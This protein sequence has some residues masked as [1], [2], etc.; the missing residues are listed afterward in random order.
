MIDAWWYEDRLV[1]IQ[2]QWL[3]GAE[4]TNSVFELLSQKEVQ[5]G[6]ASLPSEKQWIERITSSGSEQV[7]ILSRVAER[8]AT[9][10]LLKEDLDAMKWLHGYLCKVGVYIQLE[11]PSN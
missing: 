10:W 7:R 8:M 5:N 4:C 9:R 6:L 3:C 2:D 1:A 11:M